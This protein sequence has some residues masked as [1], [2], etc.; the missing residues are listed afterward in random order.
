MK[1]IAIIVGISNYQHTS[2]ESLPGAQADAH[3]F[4]AALIS[5]GLPPEW[6]HL[7]VDEQATKAQ[8]IKTFYDCRFQFDEEAKLI[9]YFAGHGVR[10]HYLHQSLPESAL[11]L[12]ETAFADSLATGLRLV[13]LMQLIRTLKPAQVFLFI[14]ACHSRLNHIENPLNMDVDLLSTTN[15][16]GFFC[17]LSSGI[18]Q[19]YEDGELGYGYFTNAL[20]TALSE[21]RHEKKPNCHDMAERVSQLLKEQDLPLPEEYYIGLENMWPLMEEWEIRAKQPQPIGSI[22]VWRR[23]V[24]STLQDHLIKTPDSIIWIWGDG[25]IG[26]ST[27]AEQIRRQNSH[28]L[29]VSIPQI[30]MQIDDIM[31]ILIKEIEKQLAVLFFNRPTFASLSQTLRYI[32]QHKPGY[33][34]VLDHLNHLDFAN[35]EILL[36]EI[37][38]IRLPCILISRYSYPVKSFKVRAKKIVNWNIGAMDIREIEEILL[39]SDLDPLY[40]HAML[41]ATGGNPL[42]IRHMLTKVKSGY[43]L[44]DQKMTKEYQ[45]ALTAIYACGGFVDEI[46][47]QQIFHLKPQILSILEKFGLIRYSKEGCFP[48]DMALEIVEEQEWPLDIETA[49]KYWSKQVLQTPYH[50]FSC[51]SLVILATQLD[52]L[53]DL[54]KPLSICLETLNSYIHVTYLK[55]LVNIFLKA[56]WQDLL[57]KLTDYLVDFEEFTIAEELIIHLMNSPL[58]EIRNYAHRINAKQLIWRNRL[59]ECIQVSKQV[60]KNCRSQLIVNPIKLDVAIAHFLLG[61]WIEAKQVVKE[62]IENKAHLIPKELGIAK[63]LLGTILGLSG[64]AISKGRKL[65]EAGIQILEGLKSFFWL[66]VFQNSLGELLWK[67]AHHR[68]AL[69][70]LEKAYEIA[71]VLQHKILLLEILRN[72]AH[73]YLQLYGPGCPEFNTLLPKIYGF[74]NEL[75]KKGEHW[76]KIRLLNTL[77]TVHAYRGEI[78]CMEELLQELPS[79]TTSNKHYHVLT[80]TN[81]GLLAGLKNHTELAHQYVSQALQLAHSIHNTLAIEQIKK[82]VKNCSLHLTKELKLG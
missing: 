50:L 29:Y 34:L 47:F 48:H 55:D 1:I 70:F 2:F 66:A 79:L 32:M 61:N 23:H 81:L 73:A 8:L 30:K 44:N 18:H 58:N 24:L 57:A 7:I 75:E 82:D 26:K 4:H 68:S 21:L 59:N 16:K 6:I 45:K 52:N 49:V 36:A 56:N 12:H 78:S 69:I 63:S 38:S 41:N 64:E 11:V 62:V 60:I 54:K 67:T 27:L 43:H 37:D 40:A 77:A 42:K 9:F 51:R 3:R 17:L 76:E 72:K 13:E 74:F 25:G 19:S 5:W 46:L 33:I 80:L 31:K 35:L 22:E 39:K 10:G 20:L 65:I 15:S 28:A 71:D 14:D 53:E